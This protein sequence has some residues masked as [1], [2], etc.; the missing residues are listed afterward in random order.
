MNIW[1][2]LK[3]YLLKHGNNVAFVYRKTQVTYTELINMVEQP[4]GCDGIVICDEK[5][6]LNQIISMLRCFYN[7]NICIPVNFDYGEVYNKNIREMVYRNAEERI[8][9]D[10]A[11]IMFTSGSTGVPKGAM[12]T[13]ENIISNLMAINGYMKLDSSDK[14]LVSR[15]PMHVAVFTGEI[16]VGLYSGATIYLYDEQMIP[17][18]LLKFIRQNK[19]SVFANTPTITE[20]QNMHSKNHNIPIIYSFALQKAFA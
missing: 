20:H 19:I 10:V 12:L 16:L 1:V 9:N 7:K 14:I 2:Y 11:M 3:Q 13:H 8:P 4:N 6:R 5:D 17:Q 15:S 18:R